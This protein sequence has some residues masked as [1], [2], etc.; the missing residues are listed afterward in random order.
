MHALIKRATTDLEGF[1][2]VHLPTLAG[3][4][5]QKHVIDRLSFQQ[6][7]YAQERHWT[8]LR[9]LDFAALLRVLDQNWF[10]LAHALSLPKEARHWVKELQTVRNKWAHQS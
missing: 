2:S 1:L 9:D 6:Q 5:W 3:D 8:S 7:R 10:E 4:W